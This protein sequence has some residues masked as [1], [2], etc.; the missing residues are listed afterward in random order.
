MEHES[1]QFL[2]YLTLT[3]GNELIAQNITC[4]NQNAVTNYLH[5]RVV[6]LHGENFIKTASVKLTSQNT[7]TN[8][9]S[10]IQSSIHKIIKT[11][12]SVAKKNGRS[13]IT[14]SDVETSVHE[15]FCQISPFCKP[16]Q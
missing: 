1:R 3:I 7:P 2:T 6:T 13:I 16:T 5:Q 11:A 4:D 9:E 10:N 8:I 12:S 15:N 14:L